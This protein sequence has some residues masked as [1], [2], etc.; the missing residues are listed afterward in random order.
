[1]SSVAV[2]EAATLGK[3]NVYDKS[4]WKPEKKKTWISKKF[5]INLH[6]FIIDGLGMQFTVC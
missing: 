1:M 3:I 4:D 5:Y 6:L 2:F